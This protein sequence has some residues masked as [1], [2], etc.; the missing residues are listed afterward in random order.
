MLVALRIDHDAV[1]AWHRGLAERIA[2]LPGHTVG[3]MFTSGTGRRPRQAKHL[4]ALESRLHRLVPGL[5][6]LIGPGALA[7]YEILPGTSPDLTI[8]LSSDVSDDD[9][10]WRLTFDAVQGEPGLLGDCLDGRAPVATLRTTTTVIATGRLG[11]ER[12]DVVLASFEDGLVRTTTLII[13][14]LQGGA[15]RSLPTGVTDDPVVARA[16][17]LGLTRTGWRVGEAVARKIAGRL[18]RLRYR[19]PHWRV[20]WR[21]MAGSPDLWD[22][23][24]H[25]ESGWTGLPD[26][27]LRFYAD[28]FPIVRDGTLTLFVEEYDHG[29][30]KGIISAVAFDAHGPIGVPVPVLDLPHHLSYPFV[31]EEDG[32]VWM[33]PESCATGT[34]DLYRATAFPGGWVHEAQLVCG[35]VASDA[36]LVRHEGVWWLF[37]T[38]RDQAGSYS[39][40]LHLWSA[41]DFRGP[42]TA[43]AKNPVLIDV[44]SA[45]PAGRIVSRDGAVMRPVQ[46]CRVEYG[47]ALGLARI[48]RLDHEGYE[49]HVESILGAG[50]QWPGHLLHTLN[51]AGGFEFID[52]SGRARRPFKAFVR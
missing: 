29:R 37:A 3:V 13:A 27:G 10:T 6:T 35:V 7:R 48:L 47:H 52:G 18:H 16:P 39:D 32:D 20:G 42:W 14:A 19:S 33:I 8:D 51:A 25:P 9:A 11:T 46:D 38:V 28:P 4:F 2:A 26:D 24:R 17:S 43:H 31:F 12:P 21:R 22:L 45:R 5:S 30:R 41:P 34:I 15:S 40:A 1:R 44:A 49:Q 50:P 23:R 36:T